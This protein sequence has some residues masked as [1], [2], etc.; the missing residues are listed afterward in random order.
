MEIETKLL[1]VW[2]MV[3]GGWLGEFQLIKGSD[4]WIYNLYPLCRKDFKEKIGE[5]FDLNKVLAF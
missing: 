5:P 3:C 2:C 4:N 1:P